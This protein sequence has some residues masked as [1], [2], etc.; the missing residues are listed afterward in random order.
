VHLARR[1]E[2]RIA[3][4]LGRHRITAGHLRPVPELDDLL[5]ERPF[6]LGPV[7]IVRRHAVQALAHLEDRDRRLVELPK[8][9]GAVSEPSRAAALDSAVQAA[10][11]LFPCLKIGGASVAG[12]K[13]LVHR[14]HVPV[15][16]PGRV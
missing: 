10:Q 1:D 4:E 11:E 2:V 7:G 12:A 5:P 8:R 13:L 3:R 16:M 15:G 6:E 9:D 14:A